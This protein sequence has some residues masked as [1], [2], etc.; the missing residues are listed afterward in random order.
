MVLGGV[1]LRSI[2]PSRK[3]IS[4]ILVDSR[5]GDRTFLFLVKSLWLKLLPLVVLA[6]GY[7][8]RSLREHSF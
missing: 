2:A 4:A 7:E 6:Q 5:S 3:P 1:V 8:Y